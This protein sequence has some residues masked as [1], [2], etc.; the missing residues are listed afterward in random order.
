MTCSHRMR[1]KND[2]LVYQL[3]IMLAITTSLGNTCKMSNE[4]CSTDEDC[5]SKRC[6]KLHEGTDPRCANSPIHYP[7]YFSYQCEDGLSCGELYACCAPFWG[8]CSEKDD[9]C[10]ESHVCRPE[11]GFM[12]DRC[13]PPEAAISLAGNSY[14]LILVLIAHG[15]CNA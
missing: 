4:D 7:C 8:V 13:L 2:F 14:L 12:Y 9:C 15:L 3:I 10:D 1:I 5:C 6:V 11:E